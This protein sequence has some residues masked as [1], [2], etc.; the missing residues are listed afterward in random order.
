MYLYSHDGFSS[1]SRGFSF[2]S[3]KPPLS[4]GVDETVVHTTHVLH[5]QTKIPSQSFSS[6]K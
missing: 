2:T 4:P 3:H 6:T 1:H 5:H